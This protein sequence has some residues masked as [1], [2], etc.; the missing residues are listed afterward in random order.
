MKCDFP[1]QANSEIPGGLEEWPESF[2]AAR[3]GSGLAPEA[4][5]W[6]PWG[7]QRASPVVPD[8]FRAGTCPQRSR[9]A[10]LA[11]S[12]PFLYPEHSQ[13]Y[14]WD[15]SSVFNVI[16]VIISFPKTWSMYPPEICRVQLK[17]AWILNFN[18]PG[19]CHSLCGCEQVDQ[20]LEISFS[21]S[22]WFLPCKALS[23]TTFLHV[24]C[25]HVRRDLV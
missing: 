8:C 18:K 5:S 10:S 6:V 19:L 2:P 14:S 21:S 22:V 16:S 24:K 25:W 4:S 1:V 9:P 3:D 12:S 11:P 17:K 20:P 15:F 23:S 7:W 13:L